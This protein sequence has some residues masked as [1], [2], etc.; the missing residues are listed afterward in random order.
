LGLCSAYVEVNNLILKNVC[1]FFFC[2]FQNATA[3]FMHLPTL[4]YEI[5]VNLTTALTNNQI[6]ISLG[7][8]VNSRT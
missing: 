6:S 2:V 8:I 5:S 3:G 7:Q 4:G 1:I